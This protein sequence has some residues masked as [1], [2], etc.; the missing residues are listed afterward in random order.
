MKELTFSTEE[1]SSQASNI[2]PTTS[3]KKPL[4][5]HASEATLSNQTQPSSERSVTARPRRDTAE[6]EPTINV[7]VEVPSQTT[8]N[9]PTT[10][11]LQDNVAIAEAKSDY[12]L[13]H[14]RQSYLAM[15]KTASATANPSPIEAEKITIISKLAQGEAEKMGSADRSTATTKCAHIEVEKV[16]PT[17]VP[18]DSGLASSDDFMAAALKMQTKSQPRRTSGPAKAA[19][20][21]RR[22]PLALNC[23]LPG[24]N[25]D[26]HAVT[27][28]KQQNILQK[29]KAKVYTLQENLAS[30]A[31]PASNS[32]SAKSTSKSKVYTLQEVKTTRVK[33]V[34]DG[35][36]AKS[37][38]KP[39]EAQSPIV[40]S[41]DFALQEDKTLVVKPAS[42]SNSAKSNTKSNEVQNPIA[43]LMLEQLSAQRGLASPSSPSTKSALAV[44]SGLPTPPSRSG[45]KD[46]FNTSE[47]SVTGQTEIKQPKEGVRAQQGVP[48]TQELLDWDGTM[49]PPPCDW[50]NDR[51][52][53]DT[54]SF[55]ND[56][57]MEWNAVVRSNGPTPRVDTSDPEFT[58]P[59]CGDVDYD[60]GELLRCWNHN[61][62]TKPDKDFSDDNEKRENQ[63]SGSV[64]EMAIRRK[65]GQEA[66][67]KQLKEAYRRRELEIAALEPELNA[68]APKIDMYLR[69]A[70][71]R[72]KEQIARIYNHYVE[73]THITEDICPIDPETAAW[74]V[75]NTH[76]AGVPFIVA[77]RG[78]PPTMQDAQ[79]RAGSSQNY[80]MPAHE[81]IIGF[82]FAEDCS[83]GWNGSRG[84]RSRTTANLQIYVDHRFTRMGVGRN[85]LDRMMYS[86]NPTTYSFE[87]TC[88]WIDPNSSCIY[89]G[90]LG[91]WHQLMIQLSILKE[92]DPNY[93]GVVRFLASKFFFMEQ[94]RLASVGRTSPYRETPSQWL[95]LVFFQTEATH[96]K[97]VAP[98]Y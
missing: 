97:V 60:H 82:T 50:E 62:I 48:A 64:M 98:D 51:T 83:K 76:E 92:R 73:A 54:S 4:S 96:G 75:Y 27:R 34:L 86:L 18:N 69:P 87:N 32:N 36:S 23:I 22:D 13:P 58:S 33:P 79:G 56:Y 11:R 95:D 61:Y 43:E 1:S 46:I 25:D 2:T 52:K 15:R 14:M 80:V 57:V 45:Q 68:F 7:K 20:A 90:G 3:S 12:V 26:F 40:K 53:F 38:T 70:T 35:S 71:I 31:K 21:P 81:N 89:N 84:G 67:E 24:T 65:R 5:S 42:D 78:N 9:M 91:T 6:P 17:K 55:T 29:G 41:K 39:K 72:D 63:T 30:A 94:A 16:T 66:R 49:V 88:D 93:D 59:T 47:N 85:M 44:V 74:M 28:R 8:D 19:T 37:N 77:V 10:T